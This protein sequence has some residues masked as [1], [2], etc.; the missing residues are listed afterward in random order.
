MAR[1]KNDLEETSVE[2]PTLNEA[3]ITEASNTQHLATHAALEHF[4]AAK[5]IGRIETA[6]FYETVSQ[7]LI[8]ETAIKFQ[9]NKKYKG[10]PFFDENKNV[11]HVSTFDEFC[12]LAFKKTSRRV[13]QIMDN[14]N[15]LGV[16]LYEQAEKLGFQQRDYAALKA[17][18]EDDQKL[19]KAAMDDDNMERDK[20]LALMQEM[21]AKHQREKEKHQRE[22][23][24]LVEIGKAKDQ[25]ISRHD[26]TIKSKNEQIAN[27][28]IELG[29]K[30]AEVATDILP[31]TPLIDLLNRRT[32]DICN[33]LNS[34][35]TSDIVQLRSLFGNYP[36][37]HIQLIIA[38]NIGRIITVAYTIADES[39]VTPQIDIT[40]A[41]EEPAKAD[42]EA[43]AA[44]EAQQQWNNDDDSIVSEQV[45]D[46][47]N[48]A[49]F[50]TDD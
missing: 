7:K 40:T 10:L 14:Y 22:K 50:P 6:L 28:E 37:E 3:A 18:P 43:F 42:A 19:L 2:L 39:S 34:S 1:T 4:E 30:K 9:K 41:A 38:Q 31:E 17:L 11:K 44:W 8:A 36:P 12:E 25:T 48:V 32:N 33:E 45:I 47:S 49:A 16:D 24:E 23:N 20:L 13:R 46:H 35:F 5:E 27:L 29:H 26:Q 15:L 21:A